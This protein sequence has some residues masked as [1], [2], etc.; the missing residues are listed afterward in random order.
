M[1]HAAS[2]NFPSLA[3]MRFLLG[4]A[5]S[6]CGP[7]TVIVLV[8]WYTRDEQPLRFGLHSGAGGVAYI[9][10]GIMGY[11]IGNITRLAFSFLFHLF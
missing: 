1:C 6:V 11:G 7:R 10:G 5:E 9:L 4:M 2:L 8:M 3:A